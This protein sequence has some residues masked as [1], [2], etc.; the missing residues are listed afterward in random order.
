MIRKTTEQ[1]IKE[2][3]QIHGDKYDYSLVDYKKALEKVKIKCNKC[4]LIFEKT[5]SKH[6]SGQGCKNCCKEEII[7]KRSKTTEQFIQEAKQIY[8]DEYDYSLVDYKNRATKVKIIC[9]Q[10]GIFEKKPSDFLFKKQK[11]PYCGPYLNNEKFINKLKHLY[12]DKYDYSLIDYKNVSTKVKIKCLKHNYTF[13]KFPKKLLEGYGCKYCGKESFLQ[14]ITKTTEQFIEEAK[15]I[16]GDEYDYSLVDY[17]KGY[18]KVKIICKRHKI[19]MQTP[20]SHLQGE[21]CP[22]CKTNYKGEALVKKL[23]EENNIPFECQYTFND[24]VYKDVLRFDFFL[25]KLNIIIEVQ[26]EGHF[27]PTMFFGMPKEIAEK[28]FEEQQ[29]RDKIKK[30]YCKKNNITLVEFIYLKSNLKKLEKDFYD[31]YNNIS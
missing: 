18:E 9:K 23:L 16:H 12:G 26:G 8:G 13:L 21:G 30:E 6:L 20:E 29:I 27:K 1:F 22:L 2:A 15:L 31:W 3:K 4:G 24:C 14:K 17:K 19:F 28:N 10:H 5:P 11:C 25:P 7:K